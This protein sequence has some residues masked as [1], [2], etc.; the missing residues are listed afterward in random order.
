MRGR[1]ESSA[2]CGVARKRWLKTGSQDP[3]RISPRITDGRARLAF[4]TRDGPQ[5]NRTRRRMS[6]PRFMV[7]SARRIF[8]AAY[9]LFCSC[10]VLTRYVQSPRQLAL[11]HQAANGKARLFSRD[12][13]KI[14]ACGRRRTGRRPS[15]R[16]LAGA[17]GR[18]P[19]RRG[20]SGAGL[21][22]TRAA[23]GPNS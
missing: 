5:K 8:F 7:L 16:I 19:C 9:R 10:C 15:T 12:Q 21:S 22:R 4:A 13:P 20:Q 2:T 11:S 17:F 23:A 18:P 3:T 1:T 14:L 6:T